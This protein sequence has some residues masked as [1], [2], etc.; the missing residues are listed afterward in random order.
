MNHKLL[1]IHLPANVQN[2]DKAIAELGGMSNILKKTSQN[3]N[4]TFNKLNIDLEKSVSF[5]LLLKKK[6]KV[7]KK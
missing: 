6:K 4:I 1:S 5:D 2:P 7:S 3:S